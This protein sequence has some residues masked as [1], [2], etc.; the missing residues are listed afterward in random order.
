MEDTCSANCLDFLLGYAAEELGLDNDW[1]LGEVALSQ[2]LVHSSP[3]AVN[4]GGLVGPVL[5]GGAGL[6]RHQGP[7]GVHVGGGAV[8]LLH[9]LVVVTHAYFTKVTRMVFV[10]VDSVV[11]LPSSITTTTRV[12]PVLA[13]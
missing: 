11:V 4:D 1:L 3:V 13:N 8:V 12:L 5:V 6:L 9:G 7:Q 10:I 2:H